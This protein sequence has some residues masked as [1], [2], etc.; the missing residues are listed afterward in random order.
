MS[1]SRVYRLLRIITMLQGSRSVTVDDLARELEVSRRTVFRDLNMLEMARIPYYFDTATRGYR[2]A[3]TFFLPPINLTLSEALAML[4][5]TGRI[6]GASQLPLLT[7]A[8]KAAM[9]LETSLPASIREHIGS[10]L[11][12]VS[13]R[14]GPVSDHS[15]TDGFFEQFT[16]A[17][18]SRRVC[19]IEYDSF[20]DGGCIKV[21]I[22]P[23]RLAFVGRA[24]YVIA[25]SVKHGE[26]RT[27]KLS[28][29][30]K[31]AVTGQVFSSPS[32]RRVDNHFGNAWSMI[33][34]GKM[35]DVVLRFEPKVARNVAEVR[36]HDNQQLK[37]NDDGTLDFS[38]RV[39][40]LGEISWW[41]FGYGHYVKVIS[42]Q[43][44]RRVM[45][46]SAQK[47]LR[48]YQR[49]SET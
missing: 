23:L 42:P 15:G 49:D 35:Y 20:Y 45:K 31:L 29:V 16:S 27:F 36:W 19:R 37:W 25:H 12:R 26:Q 10:V 18:G 40:G 9:K 11:D 44:L 1:I 21:T 17:I 48:L 30:R 14:I 46:D 8:R 5:L 6:S 33:P 7:N 28:R 32:R 41:I 2:I 39:D 47:I 38:V 3:S 24:W 13:F 34:E 4:V 22:H 43:A